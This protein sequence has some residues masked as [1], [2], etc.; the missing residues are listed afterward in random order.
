MAEDIHQHAAST[1]KIHHE[2]LCPRQSGFY[3]RNAPE[4]QVGE[5]RFSSPL[6]SHLAGI[7]RKQPT[8]RVP[9]MHL[10][11]LQVVQIYI[12]ESRL[13]FVSGTKVTCAYT[14]SVSGSAYIKYIYTRKCEKG[15]RKSVQ[16]F[17]SAYLKATNQKT[18]DEL[19]PKSRN[20][21]KRPQPLYL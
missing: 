12:S 19:K 3:R 10:L 11:S 18:P 21:K 6:N 9:S 1:Q 14:S 17:K 5:A 2:C 15:R 13:T 4:S 20:S 8:I 7:K 16:R